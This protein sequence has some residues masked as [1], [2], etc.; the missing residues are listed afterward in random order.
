MK[1]FHMTRRA[2]LLSAGVFLFAAQTFGVA[3]ARAAQTFVI[4]KAADPQTLD[5]AQTIDNNDWTI[6][7]PIYQRLMKYEVSADGKGLT[8]VT[9]D[10]AKSWKAS[11]D[12]LTWVFDL[13]E[14]NAFSDGAPVDA[15]A[16]E[17]SFRRLFAMGQGPSEAFPKGI[18]VEAT[19]PLQVTFKL[20]EPFAPFLYTLANNGASIVSPAVETK[21]GPQGNTWL[22][23]HSD[24]SGPFMLESWEKGQ[25]LV[26]KPNPHYGG[27]APSLSSVRVDIIPEASA[28]RLKLEAGD[29]QIAEGLPND[30]LDALAQ[31]P[32]VAVKDFPSLLVT[33]LYLNN[34]KAPLNDVAVRQALSYSIDYG[35]IIE[36]VVGGNAK[37]MRGPI[38]DGMWGAKPDVLQYS[39]DL[40][41]AKSLL[42]SAPAV[43]QPLTLLYSDRDPNWEPIAIA[44]QAFL[45]QVGINVT[46]EKLAN[47]TMRE[48]ID[49]GDFDIAIGNWSPDFADPYM[50][51]NYWFDSSRK[52]LAGNRSFYSNP[53]VDDLLNKAARS[54]DQA[55]RT[56]LYGEVQDIV[57]NEAAYA[58]LFQK[59]YRIAMSKAVTGFVFNPMLQD[60][61]NIGDIT[62]TAQ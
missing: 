53:K 50:F 47:A 56:A 48:R 60:I 4:A 37:Q 26:L 34:Q 7:Y 33:Y 19:G 57:T 51:T 20:P 21:G 46:L 42:A 24:G 32:T 43:S 62:L 11:A 12:G 22:S 36:G 6:T 55:E 35:A 15:K 52:G 9:G 44:T 17:Y 2:M 16:V 59:D 1:T 5:P 8:S 38:P 28:R 29:V 31:S 18:T 49:K 30:Q 45:G 13:A 27:K 61:Y 54:T 25:S 10:L 40:D 23:G 39:M 3:P 14:G 41:K 58:Y